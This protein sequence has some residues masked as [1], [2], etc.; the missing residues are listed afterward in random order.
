ML[1]WINRISSIR[2]I[3]CIKYIDKLKTATGFLHHE[4][5][6]ALSASDY[7]IHPDPHGFGRGSNHVINS[8]VS[9]HAEG[10]RGIWALDQ[11]QEVNSE[12]EDSSLEQADILK[13]AT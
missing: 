6:V 10:K 3:C 1:S 8:V 7:H 11:G 13:E 9:L 4:L 5:G 12:T 2:F